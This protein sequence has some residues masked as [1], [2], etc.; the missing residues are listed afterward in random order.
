MADS[1]GPTITLTG[2]R[3]SVGMGRSVIFTATARQ[4]AG[5]PAV[6]VELWPCAEGKR[7][8]AP[9]VTNTHGIARFSL[10]FPNPG[11]AQVSVVARSPIRPPDACWIW[12]PETSDHQTVYLLKRFMLR[13]P[14]SSATLR[15]SCDDAFHAYL[16]GQ[17]LGEGGDFHRMAVFSGLEKRLRVG[18][19]LL[20]V[21]GFNGTGPAGLVARLEMR[22]GRSEQA[23]ATDGTWEAFAEKPEGWPAAASQSGAPAHVVAPVGGGVWAD[24]PVGWPSLVT[25]KAFWVGSTPPAQLACS[26][27]VRIRVEQRRIT[28]VPVDP[29]HLVGMEWEP[30]FTPLNAHWDL[31]EA[32]PVVGNYDSFNRDVIRQHALWMTEAGIDFLLVD[33]SN[34]LWDKKHWSERTPGVEDLIRATT[35]TLD[36]YA[37]MRREGIQ[38]PQITLLLGLDN[39]P[40]TT[41]E[42]L[43]EEMAWVYEH[44]VQNPRYRGLWLNYAGRPLIVPF[45]GGGPNF[46]K[47]QPPLEESPFTVRWMGSQLQINHLDRAGYWSWMDG[48]LLPV[49]TYCQG[50]PEALTIT[51]AF[52]ADGGW[53]YPPAYGRRGGATYLTQWNEAFRVRPRFLIINQWNEFAGQPD[54]GGY[55]PKKDQYVDCYSPELSDDI[56]PTSLTTK[57]YRGSGGWGYSYYNMTSALIRLYHAPKPNSTLLAVSQPLNGAIVHGDLLRVEWTTAGLPARRFTLRLDGRVAARVVGANSVSLSTRGLAPGRHMLSVTAE[58]ASTRYALSSD[59]EDGGPERSG[60]VVGSVKFVVR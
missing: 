40:A 12:A 55:G 47:S 29:D 57:A 54:G 2:E 23:I 33:W 1:S 36:V 28:R 46:R 59:Q 35:L 25:Q 26:N 34:N 8:G 11:S 27:T 41:T 52:F 16:N 42:A 4:H 32:V 60:M 48:S 39:G 49:T 22:T 30:W 31:A 56:E 9:V 38:V 3:A 18:E 14:V 51:P 7:W 17:M 43:H 24:A 20:A 15:L 5:G 13:A 10:P 44:Y 37:E 19:N 50:K 6:G 53:T 45:D 58:G 21:E